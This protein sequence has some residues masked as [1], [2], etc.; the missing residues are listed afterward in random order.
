MQ[1]GILKAMVKERIS[2]TTQ[3]VE[4]WILPHSHLQKPNLADW[5]AGNEVKCGSRLE[6]KAYG[7]AV[8]ADGLVVTGHKASSRRQWTKE[9]TLECALAQPLQ[10]P[11]IVEGPREREH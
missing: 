5:L 6:M 4:T 1:S 11:S 3:G 8:H 10:V 2:Y 7:D 9:R